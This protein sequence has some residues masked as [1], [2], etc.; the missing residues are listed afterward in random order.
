MKEAAVRIRKLS[1][2]ESE[3]MYEEAMEKQRWDRAAEREYAREEGIE[4]GRKIGIAQGIE[5][6]KEEGMELVALNML[7]K[8]LDIALISE[9]TGLTV[10]EIEKLKNDS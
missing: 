3:L 6:G 4:K 5:K 2:E 10:K 1:K 9:I 7:K 8:N